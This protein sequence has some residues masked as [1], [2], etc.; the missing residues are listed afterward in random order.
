MEARIIVASIESVL[1]LEKKKC[2]LAILSF[3]PKNY[4]TL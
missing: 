4:D 3:I 2:V 1:V